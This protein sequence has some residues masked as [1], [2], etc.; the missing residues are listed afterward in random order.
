MSSGI[1]WTA[2]CA[3]LFEHLI[4]KTLQSVKCK[5]VLNSNTTNLSVSL[6]TPSVSSYV[7]RAQP[8]NQQ[9]QSSASSDDSNG[10]VKLFEVRPEACPRLLLLKIDGQNMNLTVIVAHAPPND[11][12]EQRRKSFWNLLRNAAQPDPWLCSSM[13]TG[14]WRHP[15]ASSPGPVPATWKTRMGTI[16]DGFSKRET[17]TQR[18]ASRLLTSQPG[19]AGGRGRNGAYRRTR[20]K[21]SSEAGQSKMSSAE[22]LWR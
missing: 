16:F 19:G 3:L 1:A 10:A 4:L 21:G 2:V 9:R 6:I 13:R 12:G 22:R 20:Q 11:S 17:C 5:K 14:E 15:R 18:R 8:T 7:I